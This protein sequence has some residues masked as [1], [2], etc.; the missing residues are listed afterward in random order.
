MKIDISFLPA[1]AAAFMLVF[2]RIGTM[3][4]LLPGLGE[5]NVPQRVRL[6]LALVLTAVLLPLHRTAYE[7]DLKSFGPVL[8]MLGLGTLAQLVPA[9][10]RLRLFGDPPP[11]VATA[12]AAASA[13]NISRACL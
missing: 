5:M 7:I 6:T 4:M 10:E 3:V 13:V 2:A 1:Y 12:P 11:S 9:L 8:T